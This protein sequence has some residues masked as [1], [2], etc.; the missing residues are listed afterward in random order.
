MCLNTVSCYRLTPPYLFVLAVTQLNARWFYHNS[1]FRNPI[2][3]R[4]QATCPEYWWR[5]VLY[6]NTLFP[7]KDMVS[8]KEAPVKKHWPGSESELYRPS[9]RSLSASSVPTFT[10][11]ECHVVSVTDFYRILGF[12]DRSRYFFLQVAPQLYSRGWVDPVPDP[13]L[14]RKSGR[15]ENRTR[16]LWVYSQELCQLDHRGGRS[17]GMIRWIETNYMTSSGL[18][19]RNLPACWIVLQP[20]ALLWHK[21]NQN[22]L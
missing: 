3:V 1:V 4:D 12:L 7:V 2:M 8:R 16:D 19:P 18:E 15:A 9:D 21:T 17:A 10:D 14:L 11:R 20:T 6:I 5:N 22:S 13:L